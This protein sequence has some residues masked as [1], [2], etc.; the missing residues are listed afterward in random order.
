M[1][2]SDKSKKPARGCGVEMRGESLRGVVGDIPCSLLRW[3][4]AALALA[5]V[6]CAVVAVWCGAL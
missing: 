5:S 6:T 1:N 4:W 3:S 2:I